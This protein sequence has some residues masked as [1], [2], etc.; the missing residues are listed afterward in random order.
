MW[1]IEMRVLRI[2]LRLVKGG[3]YEAYARRQQGL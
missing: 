3:E 2:R 1:G